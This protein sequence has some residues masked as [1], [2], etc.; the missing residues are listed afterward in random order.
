MKRRDF[1]L[2]VLSSP[3]LLSGVGATLATAT[4]TAAEIQSAAATALKQA[5]VYMDEVV[6]FRGGYVW[7]YSPDLTQRFGE[8]EAK[9]TMC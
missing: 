6:S 5:A 8:M 9:P 3:L 7:S 2:S 4:A 1:T